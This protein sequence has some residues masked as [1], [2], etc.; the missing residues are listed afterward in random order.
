MSA[1]DQK[2]SQALVD[3]LNNNW[4]GNDIRCPELMR[5]VMIKSVVN[6]HSSMLSRFASVSLTS[7]ISCWKADNNW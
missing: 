2:C 7:V 1:A 4:T 5:K 6:S 3:L